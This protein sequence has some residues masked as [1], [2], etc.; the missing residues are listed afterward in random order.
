M[1]LLRQGS[2]SHR[3][4]LC[5]SFDES[6]RRAY[7]AELARLLSSGGRYLLFVH[8]SDGSEPIADGPSGIAEETILDLFANEFE[9]RR[10]EKGVT[11]MEDKPVWLSG[12]YWYERR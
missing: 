7:L 10:F 6:D 2:T 8:L 4:R 1:W 5:H 9:L 11:Q 12:W 3:P